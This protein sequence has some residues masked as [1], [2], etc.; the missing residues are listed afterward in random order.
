MN[1]VTAFLGGDQQWRH[2]GFHHDF[3][4]QGR[5]I[6]AGEIERMA[7]VGLEPEQGCVDD[8]VVASGIGA[9]DPGRRCP[10][11]QQ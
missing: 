3:G 11:R 1:G 8:N 2:V 6:D 9:A 10:E 4:D 5:R 7:V